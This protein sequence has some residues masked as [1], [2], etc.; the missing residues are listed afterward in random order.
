MGARFRDLAPWLTYG[1]LWGRLI[2]VSIGWVWWFVAVA[3]ILSL[4]VN[5]VLHKPVGQTA[6]TLAARPASSFVTGLLMLLLTGPVTILLGATIIGLAVVPFVLCAVVL[7]WITG[8]VAVAR[9]IGRTILG[10]G[11]EDTQLESLLAVVIGFASVCLLYTVPIVGLMTWALV[12]VLGLGSATLTVMAALRRERAKRRP[13]TE[14]P[15]APADTGLD[16]DVPPAAPVIPAAPMMASTLPPRAYE[17]PPIAPLPPGYEPPPVPPAPAMAATAGG[18]AVALP[19][20]NRATFLDRVV[21]GALDIVF[22]LFVF[23]MFLDRWVWDDGSATMFLC[24]AYFVTFWAW[25][26]TTLGGMVCNL[27]I[28]RLNGAP[29][30]GSDAV[31]RGLASVFSFVPLGLGFFWILK[32]PDRQAW[33]DKIAGTVVIKD[34]SSLTTGS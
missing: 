22:V 34:A 25:K 33:H 19:G 29:L 26:S 5:L 17:P 21:A 20:T 3:L 32:D 15:P 28:V 7:A 13:K 24:F 2:V 27:R 8:K 6:D 23:N 1:L 16:R 31:V 12:G 11:A 10:Y 4:A 9:W 18:A 14:P 30:T